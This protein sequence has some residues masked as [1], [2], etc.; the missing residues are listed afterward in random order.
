[1]MFRSLRWSV[2]VLGAIGV[3]AALLVALQ[4]YWVQGR[5]GHNATEVFVSK[6][7]VADILPPPLYLIEMR[8][9]LSQA[10]EGSMDAAEARKQFDRLAGEYQARV[11]HWQANPPHGL[12]NQL[13]GHQHEAGQTF[14]AAA[15]SQIIDKLLAGD[16]AGARDQLPAVHAVYLRHR[17]GVDETVTTANALAASAMESFGATQKL[18]HR[19]AGGVALTAVVLVMLVYQLVLGSIQGPLQAC[20]QLARRIADG[21]LAAPATGQ[22]L[23]TDVIGQLEVALADMQTRLTDLVRGVRDSADAVATASNQIATGNQDLSERTERQ[24]AALEQTAASMKELSATV[25]LNAGHAQDANH[26]AS[27]ASA[28]ALRGGEV[29][30]RV[31]QTM[32][33]I[34]ASAQRITDISGVIDG[35][36]FQTNILALNAAV[37]AARAGE[38]GRGFAVVAAEVR[39]L[40]QRSAE[41]SKEIRGLIGA[42]VDAVTQGTALVDQAGVTMGEIVIAIR[43]VNG[44]V[45]QISLASKDQSEGMAQ[46][47]QAVAEI[48][49]TTQQNAALVQESA[50]AA[51]SLRMQARQLVDAVS[52]FRLPAA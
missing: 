32:Q 33:G 44:I 31:V 9:V 40:A 27:G 1:M 47:G 49:Q 39:S 28:V 14:M 8:L 22:R 37:E 38:H 46:V 4:G 29:V 15:Q 43:S 10:V 30:G 19:L 3:V 50:A 34:N 21:H 41:A 17:A 52:V 51:D 13:L 2:F 36:A 42:S 6:D 48:D 26:L 16:V 5:M 45:G 11:A 7:V 24:A 12:E 25:L 35:I 18:S 20:T 23:R